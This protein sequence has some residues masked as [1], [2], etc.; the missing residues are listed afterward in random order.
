MA[1]ESV[2]VA[3]RF[4]GAADAKLALLEELQRCTDPVSAAQ[5]AIDW[6]I[7]HTPARRGVFA[8]TD[9]VRGTLGCIDS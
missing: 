9:N 5:A 7:A 4:S 8:A 2:A 3:T 1:R 6:L